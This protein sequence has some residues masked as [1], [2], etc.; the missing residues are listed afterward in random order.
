[1]EERYATPETMRWMGILNL[2]RIEAGKKGLLP[3]ELMKS[4]FPQL[5]K[6]E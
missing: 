4:M 5:N 3:P 1:V 2:E 6:E